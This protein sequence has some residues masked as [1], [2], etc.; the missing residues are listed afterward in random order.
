MNVLR[1]LRV[2]TA[3][4]KP[5]L[6]FLGAHTFFCAM[7]VLLSAYALRQLINAVSRNDL[8]GAWQ[9]ALALVALEV[10]SEFLWR[11]KEWV[12]LYMQPQMRSHITAVSSAQLFKQPY[13]FLQQHLVG[14]LLSKSADLIAVPK[15]IELFLYEFMQSVLAIIFSVG[16]VYLIHPWLAVMLG[17]WVVMHSLF[18]WVGS[19]KVKEYARVS[20]TATARVRGGIADMI[21]NILVVVTC[22]AQRYEAARIGVLQ[23]AHVAANRKRRLASLL[24]DMG[25]GFLVWI[26]L[27]VCIAVLVMLYT[28]DCITP[29]DFAFVLSVN[30]QLK[31]NIW[32]I[33]VAFNKWADLWAGLEAGLRTYFRPYTLVDK[34]QAPDIQVSR[35][36]ITFDRVSFTYASQQELF[37]DVSLQI[38][39]GQKVGLVGYSGSGKTTLVQLLLRLY[40][41]SSGAIYID[42]QNIAEVTQDSLHRALA[43][44]PQEPFL[45]HRSIKENIVYGIDGVT[46]AMTIAAA[47]AAAAHEFIMQLP[48]QYDTLIGERGAKLSGGQRQRIA[49]ARALLKKASILILDE[50]TAALDVMTEDTIQVSLEQWFCEHAV[51]SKQTVLVIA[52]RFSTVRHLDRILVFDNGSIVQDGTHEELMQQSG[53]YVQLVQK[54]IE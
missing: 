37:R 15:L 34:S 38:P 46:D 24:L 43:Y 41:V 17:A 4:F 5:H 21:T 19:K 30:D 44:V 25:Q 22:A 36:A 32:A 10:V 1:F 13:A 33:G 50:A 23:D 54:G 52:H 9:S 3:P 20:A 28:N 2:S 12:Y 11:V 49:L 35:G 27:T 8:S 16:A 18:V 47:R 29:G 42:G 48:Q 45:F 31:N 40:D 26:S 7:Y 6:S 14:S 53:L 51:H 39:A